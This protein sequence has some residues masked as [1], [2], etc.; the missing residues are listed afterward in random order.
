MFAKRA[1]APRPMNVFVKAGSKADHACRTRAA[2]KPVSPKSAAAAGKQAAKGFK[3]RPDL[4]LHDQG[5]KIIVD[6][7]YTNF[8]LG[9]G[10][11]WDS[12]DI[13]NIDSHLAA[14]MSDHN[15]NNVMIQYFRG[16][17]AITSTFEPSTVIVGAASEAVSQADV[18]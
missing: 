15:L 1:S 3:P 12:A 9:G 8:F 16:A 5:G 7:V 6:L 2:G 13:Q 4:D 14:A 11:S 18:E 17:A 10:A